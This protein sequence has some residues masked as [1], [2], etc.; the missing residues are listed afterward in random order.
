MCKFAVWAGHYV[1]SGESTFHAGRNGHEWV[2]HWDKQGKYPRSNTTVGQGIIICF[3]SFYLNCCLPCNTWSMSVSISMTNSKENI[4]K[5][6][7]FIILYSQNPLHRLFAALAEFELFNWLFYADQFFSSGRATW[8]SN[9]RMHQQA[10]KL[11]VMPLWTW[12][13]NCQTRCN[14]LP[15]MGPIF[16]HWCRKSANTHL[17]AQK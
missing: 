13:M 17:K 15:R 14:V 8:I 7:I 12:T 5:L 9:N 6:T 1:P 4:V 10:V 2:H 3:S 11:V 16:N